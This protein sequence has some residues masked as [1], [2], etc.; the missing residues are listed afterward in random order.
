MMMMMMSFSMKERCILTTLLLVA[1]WC[2]E[3]DQKVPQRRPKAMHK[4]VALGDRGVGKSSLLNMLAGDEVFTDN[5]ED[6]W[7][8]APSA[9]TSWTSARNA[10]FMGRS[11]QILL[12]LIDTKAATVA[13]HDRTNMTHLIDA[14]RKEHTVDL[15]LVCID[16]TWP[17]FSHDL[18]KL[19]RTLD[20]M[21]PA[22]WSNAAIVFTKWYLKDEDA[23][24]RTAQFQTFLA[25]E[26][27]KAPKKIPFFFVNSAFNQIRSPQAVRTNAAFGMTNSLVQVQTLIK[28]ITDKERSL[29]LSS[30]LTRAQLAEK[31]KEAARLAL[32]SERSEQ[33]ELNNQADRKQEV[34]RLW[35]QTR[36]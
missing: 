34:F 32:A 12:R 3:A 23:Q 35:L 24:L 29:D 31:E 17:Y 5:Q 13:E 2:C 36:H 26:F 10:R 22:F 33:D 20:F 11:D 21:F 25:H 27:H 4:I 8:K 6:L 1:A 18:L 7:F 30:P 28:Y 15:F 14:I 19:L 9:T 16:A